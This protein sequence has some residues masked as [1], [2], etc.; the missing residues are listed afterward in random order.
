MK[1]PTLYLDTSVIGGYFDDEWREDTR[2]LWAQRRSGLWQFISSG[3]VAQEIAG[4]P[5]DVRQLF[6]DT[7]DRSKD[8]LAMTGEI[9]DLALE[10]LKA[11]VVPVKFEDDAKHVATC[12]VHRVNYL[13]SWNFKHLVNVRREAGFNAVNLLQGYPPVSIVNPKELIYG[14]TDNEDV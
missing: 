12:T 14:N 7:F 3:L 5:P 10:Y 13:V 11:G 6:E 9:E 1:V 2:E 4:A 8:L